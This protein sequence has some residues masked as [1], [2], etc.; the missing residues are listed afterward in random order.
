MTL[1]WITPE[2]TQR[3]AGSLI[4]FLWQGAVIAVVTAVCLRLLARRSAEWRYAVSCVALAAMLAAPMLTFVFYAQTGAVALRLLKFEGSALVETTQTSLGMANTA[5][6]GR[7][8]VAGRT[9]SRICAYSP[10]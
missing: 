9:R 4:H 3:L 2:F 1:T 8:P 6:S 10:P 5:A 7:T